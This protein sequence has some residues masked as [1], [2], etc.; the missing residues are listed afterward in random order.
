MFAA[1]A[2]QFPFEMFDRVGDIHF[3]SA[4]PSLFQ[5]LV[6]NA[7]RRSDKRMSLQIFLIAGLLSD[8]E[9]VCMSGAFA[10][11]RLCC[12]LIEVATSAMFRRM[13]QIGERGM[14]RDK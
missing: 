12:M 7:P 10:K 5:C 13:S 4:D 6:Q 8:K 14:S 9:N 2:L 1:L 3:L 11:H